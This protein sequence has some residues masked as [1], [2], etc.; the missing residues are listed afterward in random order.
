MRET[1]RAQQPP[2]IQPTGHQGKARL[3][4]SQESI[5]WGQN[6]RFWA[7]HPCYF[8][9]E[10]K[11]WYPYI[12]KSLRHLLPIVFWSGMAP[13]SNMDQK[14]KYLAQ[15]TGRVSRHFIYRT[16]W[17]VVGL[18]TQNRNRGGKGGGRVKGKRL[19]KPLPP[20]DAIR[21]VLC[22][23]RYGH[24]DVNAATAVM[25]L[26]LPAHL[27]NLV[28]FFSFVK[29]CS[30]T[31]LSKMV[32]LAQMSDFLLY[33]RWPNASLLV[34]V[35]RS[36]RYGHKEGL[37]FGSAHFSNQPFNYLHAGGDIYWP[38]SKE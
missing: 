3:I 19:M 34:F 33:L 30:T 5:L 26:Q 11:F 25:A 9:G 23:R 13:T 36:S 38:C 27:W 6:G 4:C 18:S 35:K 20:L 28:S 7:K 37:C 12:R 24:K 2:T 29:Q 10:Q 15:M 17:L 16:K 21:V 1:A 32:V 31:G 14:G 22:L 8:G